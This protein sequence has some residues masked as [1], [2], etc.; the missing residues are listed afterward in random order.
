MFFSVLKK[1]LHI[2]FVSFFYLFW[3][4]GVEVQDSHLRPAIVEKLMAAVLVHFLGAP[5]GDSLQWQVLGF[6]V[7]PQHP[8]Q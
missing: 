4:R 1:Q 6:H 8:S 2:R 3:P 5:E 7:G